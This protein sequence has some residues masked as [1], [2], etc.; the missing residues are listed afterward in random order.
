MTIQFKL[1]RAS[2]TQIT[3]SCVLST[4][5]LWVIVAGPIAAQID[6]DLSECVDH[7]EKVCVQNMIFNTALPMS[8]KRVEDELSV[9]QINTLQNQVAYTRKK[10]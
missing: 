6:V 7:V 5:L 3:W 8:S 1:C 9:L 2:F 4:V 10:I